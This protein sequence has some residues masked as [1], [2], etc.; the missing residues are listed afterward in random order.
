MPF[1]LTIRERNHSWAG[2]APIT[3]THATQQDAEA[4]LLDYVRMNWDTEVGTEPPDDSTVMISEY[5]D[6]VLEA[7]EIIPAALL[8]SC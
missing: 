1:L 4:A 2:R 3:T 5:F 8:P 6:V 7:Y